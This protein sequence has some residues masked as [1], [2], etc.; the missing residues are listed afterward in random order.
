MKVLSNK[1]PGL[2]FVCEQCFALIGNI[3]E[4]EI[5]ENEYAY[6]P[7]CHNKQKLEYNKSYN[8]IIQENKN[9]A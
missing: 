8:G 1:Y 5:Y 3:H 6:C 2:F 4:N 9:D 7:I